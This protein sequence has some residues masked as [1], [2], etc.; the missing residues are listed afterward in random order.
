MF[1]RMTWLLASIAL[2]PLLAAADAPASDFMSVD[3]QERSTGTFY[4][5]GKIE[6]I[7]E[8]DMLVDTGSS[9]VVITD[10]M[11]ELLKKTDR[12][13]YSRNLEGRMADGTTRIIPLYRLAGIRLGEQCWLYDVEA[14]V[15]PA[16]S[17]PIL[18]MNALSRLAP[19]T[20]ST[21]PAQLGLSH[22]DKPMPVAPAIEQTLIAPPATPIA[23]TAAPSHP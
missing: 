13:E 17:R 19:F 4:I 23:S 15:F 14:A 20:L 11:L 9:Y 5:A 8:L 2:A 3:I 21:Q 18:G 6:G 22:C 16:G 10:T 1:R 7:G 12:A